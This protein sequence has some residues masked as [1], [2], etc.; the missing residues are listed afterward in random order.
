MEKERSEDSPLEQDSSEESIHELASEIEVGLATAFHLDCSFL[1][2]WSVC[3]TPNK[4]C[5]LINTWFDRILR[6]TLFILVFSFD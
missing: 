6:L 1:C 3:L 5:Q 4:Y 2:S